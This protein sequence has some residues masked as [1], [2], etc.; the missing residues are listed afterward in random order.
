ETHNLKEETIQKQYVRVKSRTSNYNTYTAGSHVMEY[1]DKSI[2]SERLYLYQGFDPANANLSD[3]SLPLQPNRMDVVNQRDADLL[4]LWQRYKRSTEGSEE[5]VAFRN[6]MTE[7]MAHREHLDKSVDLIGR[8]LFGWDK[9]SNVLGAKRP[10]GKALVDDWSC[11]KS[12]VRAFE[13]KCGP[14]TQYGMKHMRAFANI[15]NEGISLEVMSKA[16]EEVCGRTYKH[17]ILNVASHHGFSG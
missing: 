4:F 5:K 6:E 10:S 3:N 2:K 8:L 1:G 16:C 12:M 15:C 7:K 9:G 11:L 14:L 17:G 13:E